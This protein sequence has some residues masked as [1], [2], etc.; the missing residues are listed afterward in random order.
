MLTLVSSGLDDVLLM[1]QT[2]QPGREVPED[3]PPH[4]PNHT[5]FEVFDTFK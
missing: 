1:T 5:K 2:Q 3:P 4:S